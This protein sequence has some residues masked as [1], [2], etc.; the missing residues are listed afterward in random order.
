MDNLS[1]PLEITQNCSECEYYNNGRC[2]L[3][4]NAIIANPEDKNCSDSVD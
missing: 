1:K 2:R 3:Y 4:D